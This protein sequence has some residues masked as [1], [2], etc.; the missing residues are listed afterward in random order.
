MKALATLAVSTLIL[1]VVAACGGA[2]HGFA[3]AAGVRTDVGKV[4]D[5]QYAALGAADAESCTTF[6]AADV[7]V[8][9]TDP[10]ESMVG[11]ASFA[12][13][14]GE[15]LGRMR[16][17]GLRWTFQFDKRD[18]GVADDGKAVWV[19]ED[20]QLILIA[21][22][23]VTERV[24]VHITS[25]LTQGEGGWEIVAAHWASEDKAPNGP[26][27]PPRE[28]ADQRATGTEPLVAA[29]ETELRAAGFTA[30]RGGLRTGL[31]P[32]GKTGWVMGL[33]GDQRVLVVLT[34][35][36][37]AWKV[38]ATQASRGFPDVPVTPEPPTDPANPCGP[39]NP[40]APAADEQIPL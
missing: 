37:S 34:E 25:V 11:K 31:A 16:A 4:L 1:T 15:D 14:M 32:G 12:A 23:D 2:Q 36:G 28:L 9:G 21:G 40:C 6:M 19:A 17:D 8:F 29:A 22:E 39:A 18:V 13:H 10:D 24:P 7:V 20:I 38:V 35:T 33:N 30:W 27:P 3:G 5:A 26:V